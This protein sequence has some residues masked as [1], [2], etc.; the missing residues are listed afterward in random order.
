M[1][2]K[3]NRIMASRTMTPPA[4][5]ASEKAAPPAEAP[6]EVDPIDI[7][8]HVWTLRLWIVCA[9]VIVSYAVVNFLLNIYLPRGT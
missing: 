7:A 9:L 5:H 6:A 1:N 3:E 4:I 2:Q 8:N